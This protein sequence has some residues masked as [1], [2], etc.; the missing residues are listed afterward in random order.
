M[1]SISIASGRPG[2]VLSVAELAAAGV[3]RVSL[4][5][6]LYRA[7][8]TGLIDAAKEIRAAGTFGYLDD[9]VT[10]P[11]FSNYLEGKA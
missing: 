5:G 3:R 10:S 1:R 2:Q 7:A 4:A 6:T 8:M 9:S 11:E